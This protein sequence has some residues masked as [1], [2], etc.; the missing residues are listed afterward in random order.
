VGKVHRVRRQARRLVGGDGRCQ[1]GAARRRR[2]AACTHPHP[3]ATTTIQSE[4]NTYISQEQEKKPDD[5][6][7]ALAQ[8]IYTETVATD[9]LKVM[10]GAQCSG[11]NTTQAGCEQ[12]LHE[13]RATSS[14]KLDSCSLYMVKHAD[15]FLEHDQ[16]LIAK[17][18]AGIRIGM[19][20]NM[21]VK[22]FRG[23]LKPIVYPDIG[24]QVDIPKALNTMQIGIRLMYHPYDNLSYLDASGADDMVLGGV[25]TLDILAL[26]PKPKRVKPQWVLR[27]TTVDFGSELQ[28]A[29]TPYSGESAGAGGGVAALRCTFQ[30]P[31]SVFMVPEENPKVVAWDTQKLKWTMDGIDQNT[32]EYNSAN[33]Q[34]RFHTLRTGAFALVQSRVVHLPYRQWKLEPALKVSE[35]DDF[36]VDDDEE[37]CIHYT[38][39]LRSFDVKIQIRDAVCQLLE[40]NLPD[41]YLKDMAPGELLYALFDRGINIMP[42]DADAITAQGYDEGVSPGLTLK[43]PELEAKLNDDVAAAAASFDFQGSRWNR[44]LGKLHSAFLT[45]ETS[46]YT[47]GNAETFDFDMALVESDAESRSARDAPGVGEL[48]SPGVKSAIVVQKEAEPK[49]ALGDDPVAAAAALLA[50]DEEKVVDDAPA[51]VEETAVEGEEEK[52]AE[53]EEA[54][55]AEGEEKKEGEAGEDEK[56]GEEGDR[57]A[58]V[59]PL[60]VNEQ[61]DDTRL[62]GSDGVQTDTHVYLTKSLQDI[63]SE[64]AM[65]RIGRSPPQ[66]KQ[67]VQQ[68]LLLTRPF[69]FS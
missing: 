27:P 61:F 31:D 18:Q 16:V 28:P 38:L 24:L 43:S 12:F 21:V 3:I 26:P 10:A 62:N 36:D 20:I 55:A 68:L 7:E 35:T 67:T 42:T 47:G 57:G 9:L 33:R 52:K 60:M 2:V 22:N 50:D 25:M 5:L 66:L 53:G 19:W 32:N 39:S 54:A 69:S 6:D 65:E 58:A 30:V 17:K 64:E 13:L 29:D 40:P 51:A 34:L 41:L 14:T 4:I 44:K 37:G 11:D 46:I 49:P 45:R 59:V 63:C 8:C 23:A 15:E 48:A 56:K 1:G